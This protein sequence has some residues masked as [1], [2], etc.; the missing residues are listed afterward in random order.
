MGADAHGLVMVFSYL[1][2]QMINVLPSDKEAI[3][4]SLGGVVT[5]MMIGSKH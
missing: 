2:Q 1:E 5:M 4:T 3:D